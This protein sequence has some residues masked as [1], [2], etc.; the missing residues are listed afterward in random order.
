MKRTIALCLSVL[1]LALLPVLAQTPAPATKSGKVHGH[2]TNPSGTSQ[3]GGTVTFVGGSLSGAA[4]KFPVDANGDYA[5]EVPPG[6]Y[7]LVYRVVGTPEDKESDHIENVKVAVGQDVLQDIDMSRKEYIDSLSPE[8][9]K[10]LEELKKKNSEAMKANEVIKH[11][12]A[13]LGTSIQDLKDA[14]AARATA[15]QT[16]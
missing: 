16:L 7:K 15:T 6:T 3:N 10:Q 5:A 12:N 9:K 8:Q 11:I 13:D 4:A 1:G 14:D 2:V